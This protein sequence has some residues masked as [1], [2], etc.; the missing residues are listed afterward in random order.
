VGWHSRYSDWPG[1]GRARGQ[2]LSLGR[3]KNFLFSMSS[4]SALV[5]TQPPVQWVPGALSLGV[6]QQGHE[7]DHSPPANAEV[8][9]WCLIN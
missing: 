9:A 6:K 4:R 2:S 1:A 7:A 5:P 3:V 8:I